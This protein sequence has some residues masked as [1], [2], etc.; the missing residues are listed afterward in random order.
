MRGKSEDPN[1]ASENYIQ[2][3][4]KSAWLYKPV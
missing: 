1:D 3:L 2:N 4:V